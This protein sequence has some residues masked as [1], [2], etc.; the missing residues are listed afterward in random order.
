M[1]LKTQ[2]VG[3]ERKKNADLNLHD[4]QSKVSRHSF[5]ST[6]LKIRVTINQKPTIDSPNQNHRV[7]SQKSKRKGTQ[8]K[9]K[10]NNQTTKVKTN[11]QRNEQQ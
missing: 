1:P 6:Y 4:Y 10:E 2:N 5:G 11:K 9:T 8:A 7:D 3:K